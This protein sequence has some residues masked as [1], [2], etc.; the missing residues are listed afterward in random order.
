MGLILVS[1]ARILLIDLF[2]RPGVS[3]D[4]MLAG[5]YKRPYCNYP[6]FNYPINH[7]STMSS[8]SIDRAKLQDKRVYCASP[9]A[10]PPPARNVLPSLARSS[11][12]SIC[13]VIMLCGTIF[14][15]LFLPFHIILVD[16]QLYFQGWRLSRTG[17]LSCL[18]MTRA[19]AGLSCSS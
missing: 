4:W 15:T 16:T 1:L 12:C 5:H 8:E 10:F 19:S 14:C 6:S 18:V 9:S 17:V 11:S 3:S 13:V 7:T 2:P